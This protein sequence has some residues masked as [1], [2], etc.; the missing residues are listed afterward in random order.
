MF[1]ITI[2]NFIADVSKTNNLELTID[3]LN[4]IIYQKYKYSKINTKQGLQ[5]NSQDLVKFKFWEYIKATFEGKCIKEGLVLKS[6][7]YLQPEISFQELKI[8]PEYLN[9]YFVSKVDYKLKVFSPKIDN[10]VLARVN[11]TCNLGVIAFLVPFVSMD[12]MTA[13]KKY[14]PKNC[15]ENWKL[16]ESEKYIKSINSQFRVNPCKILLPYQLHSEHYSIDT[17]QNDDLILLR[18]KGIKGINSNNNMNI[19]GIYDKMFVEKRN[20]VQWKYEQDNPSLKEL[21]V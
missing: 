16:I 3:N 15:N 14:C 7:E 11:N 8:V 9:G 6:N 1:Y 19:V 18:I 5:W 17:L 13:S 20:F 12:E 10:I 2:E 21:I 4:S